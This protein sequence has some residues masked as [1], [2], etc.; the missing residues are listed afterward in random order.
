VFAPRFI[1]LPVVISDSVPF[2]GFRMEDVMKRLE[3]PIGTNRWD[4]PLYT[5][6]PEETLPFEDICA[7]CLPFFVVFFLDFDGFLSLTRV[8]ITQKRQNQ[9]LLPSQ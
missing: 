2:G 4:A 5:V 8:C 3:R 9:H 7:V 6:T 1:F